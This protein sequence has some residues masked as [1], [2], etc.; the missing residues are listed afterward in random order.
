MCWYS[1]TPEIH[2]VLMLFLIQLHKCGMATTIVERCL[3]KENT[4][5]PLDG[6]VDYQSRM[7]VLPDPSIVS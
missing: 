7:E 5:Q 3:R 2:L 1:D 4:M 6:V